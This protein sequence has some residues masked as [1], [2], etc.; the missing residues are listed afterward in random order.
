[1]VEGIWALNGKSESRPQKLSLGEVISVLYVKSDEEMAPEKEAEEEARSG[2]M[3]DEPGA[4]QS[5]DKMTIGGQSSGVG[6][7][8]GPTEP[9]S[10]STTTAEQFLS[11][12]LYSHDSNRC[13]SQRQRC[14]RW[15]HCRGRCH[16]GAGAG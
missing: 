12:K 3:N 15:W 13:S 4:E 7:S 10:A 14:W 2:A 8:G 11:G 9:T 1:M 16:E 6:A 5:G